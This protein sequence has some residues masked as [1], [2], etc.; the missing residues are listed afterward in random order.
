MTSLE[1]WEKGLGG[2]GW[3][4]ESEGDRRLH[5]YPSPEAVVSM[6][7]EPVTVVTFLAWGGWGV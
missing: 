4:L 5:G 1:S 2:K 3:V 6:L 7:P